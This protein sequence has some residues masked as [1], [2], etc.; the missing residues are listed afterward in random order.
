MAIVYFLFEKN[1]NLVY[2]VVPDVRF[3]QE[4][5]NREFWITKWPRASVLVT[6]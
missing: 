1:T 6:P 2:E 5:A 4:L 3:G